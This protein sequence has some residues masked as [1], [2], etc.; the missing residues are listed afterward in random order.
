[1][2]RNKR[3]EIICWNPFLA[4]MVNYMGNHEKVSFICPICG[5]NACERPC[6]DKY[7]DRFFYQG[8]FKCS[9]CSASGFNYYSNSFHI[10]KETITQLSLFK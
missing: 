3:G 6:D 1:M 2:S 4:R 7:G 9:K 10:H 5:S 8:N